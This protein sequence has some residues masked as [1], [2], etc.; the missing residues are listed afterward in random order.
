MKGQEDFGRDN[1]QSK[2]YRE[3]EYLSDC[4]VSLLKMCLGHTSPS[5]HPMRQ[6]GFKAL[7]GGSCNNIIA[8]SQHL[9]S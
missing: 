8:A 9:P 2:M 3:A 1:K 6:A 7:A 5:L 4:E